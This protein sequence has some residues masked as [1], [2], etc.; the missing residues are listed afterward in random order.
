LAVWP[1]G[2]TGVGALVLRT[3]QAVTAS[4]RSASAATTNAI[5]RVGTRAP[6]CRIS[7]SGASLGNDPPWWLVDDPKLGPPAGGA[8][9]AKDPIGYPARYPF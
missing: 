9:R 1:V 3:N 7:N 5:E 4:A 8:Q 2:E 6:L